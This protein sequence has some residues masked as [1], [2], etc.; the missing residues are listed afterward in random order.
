[1][2][3][4][5]LQL[6]FTSDMISLYTSEPHVAMGFGLILPSGTH[7]HFLWSLLGYVVPV[8]IMLL[9]SSAFQIA[10]IHALLVKIQT[11]KASSNIFSHRRGS[12]VR[13]IVAVVLPLCCQMPL[14][15]LHVAAASGVALSPEVSMAGTLFTLHGYSIISAL[16]YVVITPAFINC[17][18]HRMRRI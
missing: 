12:L 9:L 10:C 8:V 15:F 6:P 11:L 17:I 5:V 1:M 7:G 13:C 4:L 2:Y 16:I 18:L 14:L 3:P